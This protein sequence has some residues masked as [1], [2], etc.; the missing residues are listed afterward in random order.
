M[1]KMY[2]NLLT[3]NHPEKTPQ[4]REENGIKLL[5]SYKYIYNNNLNKWREF[6]RM[7]S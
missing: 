4:Y 6:T 2:L 7:S 5:Q 3:K 1:K